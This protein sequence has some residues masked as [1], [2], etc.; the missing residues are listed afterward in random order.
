MHL[1]QNG[2]TGFEPWPCQRSRVFKTSVRRWCIH[3]L[4]LQYHS[5]ASHSF[6]VF[7]FILIVAIWYAKSLLNNDR[8]SGQMNFSIQL[9]GHF[10]HHNFPFFGKHASLTSS[11]W[12]TPSALPRFE[13]ASCPCF[14]VQYCAKVAILRHITSSISG[15]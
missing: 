7:S 8:C 12:I 11:S 6:P 10:G 13:F 3:K 5:C 2:A 1:S 14:S 9:S 15:C 4:L